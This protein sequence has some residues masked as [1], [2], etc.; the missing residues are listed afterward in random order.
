MKITK[1]EVIKQIKAGLREYLQCA[2][3]KGVGNYWGGGKLWIGVSG[4]LWSWNPGMGLKNVKSDLI[5]VGLTLR[6]AILS[7]Y[8]KIMIEIPKE[9]EKEMCRFA[10]FIRVNCPDVFSAMDNAN[11]NWFNER[12]CTIDEV[13]EGVNSGK[14]DKTS[15]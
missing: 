9:C 11:A 8:S 6:H 14:I 2:R 7:Q 3:K 15:W 5:I 4:C 13:C 10:C 1:E 12:I